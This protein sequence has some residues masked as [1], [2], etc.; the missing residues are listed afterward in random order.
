MNVLS[1]LLTRKQTKQQRT[2]L[3]I[4]VNDG[5]IERPAGGDANRDRY[6]GDRQEVLRQALEA[7]QTNPWPGA[8]W[9]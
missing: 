7:W 3:A 9:N 5:F 4:T 1:R 8:S 2:N 6:T